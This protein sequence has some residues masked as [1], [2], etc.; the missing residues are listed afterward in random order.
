MVTI[1]DELVQEPAAFEDVELDIN[2]IWFDG[3]EFCY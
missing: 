1:E 2:A 3:V